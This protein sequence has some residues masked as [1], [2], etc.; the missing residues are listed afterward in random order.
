MSRMVGFLPVYIMNGFP[1]IVRAESKKHVLRYLSHGIQE[2]MNA[3]HEQ[4]LFRSTINLSAC[5]V[6]SIIKGASFCS[7]EM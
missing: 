2:E 6:N 4:H 7:D 5:P 3:Y 1:Q